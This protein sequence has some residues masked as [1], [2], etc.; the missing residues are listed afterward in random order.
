M[1]KK[2]AIGLLLLVIGAL[3]V[4]AYMMHTMMQRGF[5]ARTE[6]RQMEKALATTIRGEA[7]PSRYK[8]MKNSVASTHS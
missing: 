7:I 1:K 3:V 6:P 4:G 8:T 5:S 2:I